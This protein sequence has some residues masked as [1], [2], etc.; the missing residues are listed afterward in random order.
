MAPGQTIQDIKNKVWQRINILRTFKFTLDRKSIVI[1][2]ISFLRPILEYA[3]T[4]WD[5]ITKGEREDIER[6][7]L[8]AA[9]IIS[10]ATLFLNYVYIKKL[11]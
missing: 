3:D 6:I 10:G 11:L 4:V 9:R 1:I 5:N 8:E 7:Q 2:Y